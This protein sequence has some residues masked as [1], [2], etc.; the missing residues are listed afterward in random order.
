[1]GLKSLVNSGKRVAKTA[2][3]EDGDYRTKRPLTPQQSSIAKEHEKEQEIVDEAF[4][5]VR[6]HYLNLAKQREAERLKA[7]QHTLKANK[8]WMQ[9][10]QVN[11]I[12]DDGTLVPT[13]GLESDDFLEFKSDEA[14]NK[15][16]DEGGADRELKEDRDYTVIR[17]IV[18]K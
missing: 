7:D 14:Y 17:V 5:K 16:W 12:K 18:Q 4:N 2:V 15:W 8:K 9:V 10:L 6:N 1:M 11:V 13:K 3:N